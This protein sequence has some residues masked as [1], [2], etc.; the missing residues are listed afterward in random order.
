MNVSVIIQG[1]MKKCKMTVA[2]NV[3]RTTDDCSDFTLNM[4]N[5]FQVDLPFS[6]Y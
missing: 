3:H 5:G 2:E 1:D 6:K 4:T